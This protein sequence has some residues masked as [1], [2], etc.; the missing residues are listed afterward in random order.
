MP[1]TWRIIDLIKWAESYFKEKGFENPRGEIEWLLRSLLNCTRIDVYLRFEEPLSK[2]QL[3]IL[4]AWVMR[5]LEKE[6]LQYIT[7]SCDFYGREFLVNKDVLIPRPETERLIDISLDK[8][9]EINLPSIIDIGTG[10][11]CIAITLGNEIPGA[12]VLG[13]DISAEALLIANRNKESLRADNTSF[14]E[15]IMTL[16]KNER[17]E[18]RGFGTFAVKHRLP[19]KARNP[20]TGDPVY[21]PERYVPVFKPSKA[22]KTTVN[23]K[24]IDY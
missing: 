22:M 7:G 1:K 11:G 19:K 10:S 2:S 20:K 24:L 8:L 16:S 13:V 15:I 12:M 17:I 23:D 18:L 5:R 14:K 21:L 9:K 4:R 3:S 6:P